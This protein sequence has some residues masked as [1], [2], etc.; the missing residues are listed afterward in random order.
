MSRPIVITAGATRNPLDAIRHLSAFSTGRTGVALAESLS[1]S[2]RVHLLGSAEACLRATA[3]S[4]LTLEEYTS[5]RDLMDRLLGFIDRHPDAIVVHAA[6]VG[7]YEL[8]NSTGQKIPSGQQEL[9]LRLTPTPK[10]IDHLRAR[11]ARISLVSFKAA[12][13]ETTDTQLLQLAQNQQARTGS[14][15]VFANVIGRLGAQVLLLGDRPDW[16]ATRTQAL[17]ALLAQ[18]QQWQTGMPT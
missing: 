15:L 10:I 18:L 1:E 5:T 3:D 9:V 7:D 16:H 4:L 17:A 13:P 6:A 12:S 2:G 14:D 11:S 8:A